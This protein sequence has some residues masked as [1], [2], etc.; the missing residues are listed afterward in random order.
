M[1][2]NK[3]LCYFWSSLLSVG[4]A[5]NHTTM[6]MGEHNVLRLPQSGFCVYDTRGFHYDRVDE[7]AQQLSEWMADGVHHNQICL[8]PR[9]NLLSEDETPFLKSSLKFATRRVNCAMVVANVAEIYK[10]LKAADK[11]PL[12]SLRQLFSSPA[13]RKC[14]K[15]PSYTFSVS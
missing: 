12:E 3:N 1:S 5:S 7:S 2:H 4:S 13:L 8:R 14:S 6:F 9:D 11:E 15:F 10:S